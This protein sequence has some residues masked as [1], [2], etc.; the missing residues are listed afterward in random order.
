M[1]NWRI[2]V[3]VTVIFIS[4]FFFVSG[5]FFLTAGYPTGY[6]T[7][8]ICIILG[9]GITQWWIMDCIKAERKE[10]L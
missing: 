7:G 4:A 1:K 10:K 5:I 2:L 6:V 9:L 8:G 3:T